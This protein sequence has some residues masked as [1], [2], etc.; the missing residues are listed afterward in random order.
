M[1]EDISNDKLGLPKNSKNVIRFLTDQLRKDLKNPQGL[2]IEGPFKETMKKLKPIIDNE[3][4]PLVISVGDIVSK[5]MID[6]GFVLDIL[7]VD[8]KT[9]RKPIEPLT[10]DVDQ[11]LYAKNPPGTITDEAWSII[12]QAIESK[13][14]TKVIIDG[15]ED[16][17]TLVTVLSAPENSMVIYGQPNKGIVVVKV[18]KKVKEK[19]Y[20]I[21]DNMVISS[22]S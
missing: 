2:L 10:V 7:I 15:E 21:V 12:K 11:C 13:E 5:H 8:N 9:M 20:Q 1:S 18:T 3:K 4:P 14:Q 16:L 17:L 6:Y 22:K 19:M